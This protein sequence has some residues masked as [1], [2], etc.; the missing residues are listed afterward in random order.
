[1]ILDGGGYI[2]RWKL[3]SSDTSSII[4]IILEQ[5]LLLWQHIHDISTSKF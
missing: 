3:F 1:M 2:W 5:S 4:P